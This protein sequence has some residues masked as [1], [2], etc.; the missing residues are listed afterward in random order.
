LSGTKSSVGEDDYVRVGVDPAK[1]F[2]RKAG[3]FRA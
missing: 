2:G 3:G 1:M